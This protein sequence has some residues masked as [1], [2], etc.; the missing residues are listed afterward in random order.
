MG[1]LLHDIVPL[2]MVPVEVD[3]EHVQRRHFIQVLV[4]P[5]R[6]QQSFRHVPLVGRSLEWNTKQNAVIIT[7]MSSDPREQR[8]RERTF[9]LQFGNWCVSLRSLNSSGALSGRLLTVKDSHIALW[10]GLLATSKPVKVTRADG[11]T[12]SSWGSSP[13]RSG[14][15]LRREIFPMWSTKKEKKWLFARP[16]DTNFV[17]WP[18]IFSPTRVWEKLINTN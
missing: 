15:I 6:L 13:I 2:R 4:Q 1:T 9:C 14:F 17:L 12:R 3:I 11:R 5:I 16:T 18:L 7:V 10:T 8:Q